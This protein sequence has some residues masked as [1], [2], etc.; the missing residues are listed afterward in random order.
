MTS[1]YST[2]NRRSFLV[3]SVGAALA[4]GGCAK[5]TDSQGAG[6]DT[7]SSA[8]WDDGISDQMNGSILQG[9]EKKS[10]IKV[11]PQAAV[12][13]TDF[14][15]R[16]RTLLAGGSPPDVMRLNDDFLPEISEKKLSKDLEPYFSKSQLNKADYF[17]IFDWSKLP[18]GQRALVVG[19]QVRLV[20]YN[21]TMFEKEGVPL[22]PKDWTPD[23]WKWDDFLNAAKALT[24]GTSQY[25]ALV[26]H[27]TTFEDI[28]SRNN[29]GPGTFSEDGTKFTL[30]D[31]VGVE[32]IQ[33]VCDLTLKHKVQPAWGDIQADQAA[34][35]LFAAGKVGMM[36]TA[37]SMIPFFDKNVKDF[38]WDLAPVPA[39]VN[40]YQQSSVIVYI[41]PDKAKNPDKAWE[42]LD[43][44]ISEEGGKL[45]AEAGLAVPVNKKAAESLKSPGEYPKNI[46][47]VIP[48]AD[49]HKSTNFTR[50]SSN[51]VALYRPQIERAY[52]GELTAEKALSSIRG[53]V[54]N[55][56]K[57]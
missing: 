7:I 23:G 48:A 20:F 34:Q 25:G 12:P 3:T 56:I 44:A 27:D 2:M 51:A 10:G 35:R 40:Q 55:A 11:R 29:G 4:L 42:Y 18:T 28:W 32:A 13:F 26:Y 49:Q 46:R 21:K 31:P 15:T 19:Q 16:F 54:E 22:P 8:A 57:A 36:E 45:F 47:L 9:F 1:G 30:A 24:K 43:Y 6:A 52:T 50:A 37:T 53:Q 33:W 38:E 39:K 41:I 17:P 14:Q 5:G